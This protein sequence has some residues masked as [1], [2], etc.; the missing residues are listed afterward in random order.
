MQKWIVLSA[1]VVCMTAIGGIYAWSTFVPHFIEAYNLTR[2]QS[3]MIFGVM[4]AVFTLATI[5]AGRLLERRGPKV[6]AGLGALFFAAGYIIASFSGGRFQLLFAGIGLVTGAGIGLAYVCPLAIGMKW[7]PNNRGLVTGVSVAG[8]GFGAVLLSA[9]AEYLLTVLGLDVLAVF[10]L[11]GIA[12]GGLAFIGAL[13]LAEPPGTTAA[14]AEP[15]PGEAAAALLSPAFLLIWLGMF[16]GTFAGLLISGNMKPIMLEIG[17]SANHAIL[18]ISLFAVGNTLG[19][20]FWG[21]AH[22][23]LSARRTIP[24]SLAFLGTVLL[25]LVFVTTSEIILVLSVLI[26]FGFGACFVVYAA[27]IVEHFGIHALPRL[28]PPCFLGYGLAALIGPPAGGWIADVTG[29]Y[30]L[31]LV[32]GFAVVL[33]ALLCVCFGFAGRRRK[34]AAPM[35]T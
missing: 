10:R 17:L 23:R 26:G 14:A 30:V 28:Y 13:L 5:P 15:V 21:H 22:D 31:A 25:P 12:F 34:A 2:A 16:A 4:I 19:R 11:I 7:F 6:T 35:P 1:G 18:T 29:S 33:I 9:M 3:G 20:L 24:I 8:F 27:S 32:L